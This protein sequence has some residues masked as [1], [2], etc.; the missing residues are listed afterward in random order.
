M[1]QITK[2]TCIILL[3]C[4]SNIALSA[5]VVMDNF[6]AGI[7]T[8]V[9]NTTDTTVGHSATQ[10]N[11]D[12]Y[13]TTTNTN[14]AGGIGAIGA[15]N[16]G[17]DY[18]GLFADGLWTISVDLSFING[19]FTDS[20]LRYRPQNA[21]FNG[22]HISLENSDFF[23]SLWQSYSVTFDTTW[24]DAEASANGWVQETGSLDFSTLWDDA[25]NSEVRIL[26]GTGMVA[27][28]DNYNASVSVVPVPAAVWLF[29]TALIGFVGISRRRKVS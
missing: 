4:F 2:Y 9:Q 17:A 28:I 13:L 18:S 24:S 1:N 5:T 21:S 22:W 6:D 3:F 29:G 26:G 12:G 15:Q 20:W 19:D 23:N 14:S 8:W 25:F 11:P 7:G 27:G 16:T 10:G